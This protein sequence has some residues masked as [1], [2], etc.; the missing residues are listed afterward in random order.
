MRSLLEVLT[1]AEKVKVSGLPGWLRVTVRRSTVLTKPHTLMPWE[2]AGRELSVQ[3]LRFVGVAARAVAVGS[4]TERRTEEI[5]TIPL[6][7]LA[8]FNQFSFA[9]ERLGGVE[10]VWPWSGQK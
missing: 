8:V 6:R 1:I 5:A 3:W 2:T 4:T 7:R 9:Y 10:P